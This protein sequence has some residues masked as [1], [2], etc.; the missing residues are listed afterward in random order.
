MVL[1]SFPTRLGRLLVAADAL[2]FK[3]KQKKSVGRI[4]NE[5][6]KTAGHI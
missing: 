6:S 3:K 5:H 4:R 1:F 2:K